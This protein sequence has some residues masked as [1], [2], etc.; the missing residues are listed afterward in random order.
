MTDVFTLKWPFGGP[1]HVRSYTA[2]PN[3]AR[4]SFSQQNRSFDPKV[5]PGPTEPVTVTA[6]DSAPSVTTWKKPLGTGPYGFIMSSILL[7]VRRSVVEL[8]LADSEPAPTSAHLFPFVAGHHI[9]TDFASEIWCPVLLIIWYIHI[10][11]PIRWNVIKLLSGVIT[12]GLWQSLRVF[13]I[14]EII[15]IIKHCPT[16]IALRPR[17]CHAHFFRVPVFSEPRIS[18]W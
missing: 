8:G 10:I 17:S 5:R 13:I 2:W 3:R 4:G 18:S 16:E 9:L 15:R 7:T 14:A 11:Q 12:K 1:Q 6:G